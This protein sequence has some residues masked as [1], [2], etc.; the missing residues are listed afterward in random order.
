VLRPRLLALAATLVFLGLSAAPAE[1]NIYTQVLRAY[2][3]NGAVPPCEFSSQ[4]LENA[5]KAIDTYGQQY[6]ADF[7]VA[8]QAALN[9]RASGA[10]APRGRTVRSAAQSHGP[11]PPL[12]PGPVTAA[13]SASLP[14]PMLLMAAFAAV[15]AALGAVAGFWWWRG[16]NPRW[17]ARWRHAWGEAG[18]RAHEGA[19]D[20]DDWLRSG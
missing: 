2:E 12:H 16:W 5:L 8:V 9:D 4:Q 20:F 7:T 18:Y 1:A 17:A 10:C 15:L 19:A 6:F 11:V 13:T 3:V 14:A